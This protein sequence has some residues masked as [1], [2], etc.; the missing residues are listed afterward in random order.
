MYIVILKLFLR[1]VLKETVKAMS[2]FY[3]IPEKSISQILNYAKDQ[4]SGKDKNEVLEL[5]K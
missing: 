1:E 5:K 3:K 2:K 4:V